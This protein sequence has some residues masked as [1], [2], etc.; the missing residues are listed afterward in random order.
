ME[1]EN[2][3]D[4]LEKES[5]LVAYAYAKGRVRVRLRKRVRVTVMVMVMVTVT[6]TVTVTIKVKV[7]V[8]VTVTVTVSV[9][10]KGYGLCVW[11]AKMKTFCFRCHRLYFRVTPILGGPL[12]RLCHRV[13]V[14]EWKVQSG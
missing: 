5:S 2:S 9:S 3:L 8:T 1:T 6:V 13:L 10:D 11:I 14:Q 12:I 7:K 4:L